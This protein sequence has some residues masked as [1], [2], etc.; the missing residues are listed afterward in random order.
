MSKR[1]KYDIRNKKNFIIILVLSIAIVCV[2]S[3]FIYKYSK[4]SKI[5]Y[6]IEAGSVLQD[7]NKNYISLDDDAILK[8]RWDDS[9]YLIY[10]EEKI[11][12]GKKVIA[13]NTITGQMKLYGTFYEIADDGK[14]IE[15]KKETILDHT[16][17][18]KFY[19]LDDREYLLVD[20]EISSNDGTIEANN[21]LLVELDKA[22]NAKLS[23]NKINLK[24]ISPT[25]LVTSKYYFDI[26]NEIL[27]FGKYDIDLKK[28]IGSTNQYAPEVDENKGN[29]SGGNGTGTGDGTGSGSGTGDGSGTGSGSGGG[30]GGGGAGSGI[31]GTNGTGN[32]IGSGEGMKP[33]NVINNN[34][35]G[36]IPDLEDIF[37][38]IKMTSIIRVVEGINQVDVDYFVYDPYNEYESVYIE[39]I[40]L[41]N[42]SSGP[43]KIPLSKTETHKTIDGLK[44]NNDYLFNFI[45]VVYEF[46]EEINDKKPEEITFES[47]TLKTKLPE[48]SISVYKISSADVRKISY[49]VN[50]QNNFK[51]SKVNVSLSFYY[52]SDD[53][54][55]PIQ[56][57]LPDSVDVSVNDSFVIGDILISDFDIAI[58]K[59]LT[60]TVESVVSEDG[61]ELPIGTSYTFK[62]KTLGGSY[63]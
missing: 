45:Y 51:I 47:I 56:K 9:Y 30:G 5:E 14:I 11:N 7:V 36:S 10:N 35:N 6:M 4:A 39:V 52:E 16:N 49:K 43:R 60:L 23:N 33:G 37:D 17:E 8:V 40:D 25:R 20:R 53:A 61:I 55:E 12:L 28:I 18:A 1:R 19:K 46:D 27:N 26:A 57:T 22:G 29:G 21:Y 31:G 41:N 3:L 15:N 48:Y 34:D 58:E 44:A 13:F 32:G 2:F 50:L 42:L 62:D 63:E 54:T 38:K 24:T 59:S